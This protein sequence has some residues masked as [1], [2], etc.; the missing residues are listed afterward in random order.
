M[1]TRNRNRLALTALLLLFAAPLA[2]TWW[3]SASGWHPQQT[4]SSGTLVEPPRDISAVTVLLGDGK[5]LPWRDSEYR[6]TLLALPGAR[7]AEACR[8]R[9]DEILRMR[10]TL[11]K[12]TER[13]RIAYVGPPLPADFV[14]T[15]A[16]LQAGRDDDGAF[17]AEHA[18]GEDSLALA[19]VDPRGLLMLR[20]A[21]GYSAQGL[22]S[23][24]QRVIY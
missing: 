24:I 8:T 19:L 2:I 20:Y 12:N 22:R 6:W 3:L 10:I 7:C 1:K 17:A 9:L 14:A 13:L 21:D 15:R 18:G 4:R 11:G 5:A 16:P 23:D